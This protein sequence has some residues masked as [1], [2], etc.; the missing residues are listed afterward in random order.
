MDSLKFLNTQSISQFKTQF[1]V[2][3]INILRNEQTGK[4]FFSYG[5]STGAVTSRYPEIPLTKPVISEV[6]SEET[7]ETFFILHNES[8]GG[9]TRMETL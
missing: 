1:G 7:G 5:S 9:A 3:D 2:E 8:E 6:A 4:C